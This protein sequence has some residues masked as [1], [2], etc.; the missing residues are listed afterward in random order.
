M[1][2]KDELKKVIDAQNELLR[3]VTQ[4][5][6]KLIRVATTS[7]QRESAKSLRTIKRHISKR[8]KVLNDLTLLL[9]DPKAAS[10]IPVALGNFCSMEKSNVLQDAI[11]DADY[12][13]AVI[14]YQNV[15][16]KVTGALPFAAVV[17]D[18]VGAMQMPVVLTPKS[19]PE[20]KTKAFLPSRGTQPENI[21]PSLFQNINSIT[22]NL[23]VA[24]EAHM[25]L[26]PEL[27]PPRNKKNWTAAQMAQGQCTATIFNICSSMI[28][29]LR[30]S[31]LTTEEIIIDIKKFIKTA[32]LTTNFKNDPDFI[33]ALHNARKDLPPLVEKYPNVS[34]MIPERL[35]LHAILINLQTDN[36]RYLNTHSPVNKKLK[37]RSHFYEADP[38]AKLAH[39]NLRA[40]EL[41]EMLETLHKLPPTNK[42]TENVIAVQTKFKEFI[43]RHQKYEKQDRAM[44]G[45]KDTIGPM[46]SKAKHEFQEKVEDKVADKKTKTRFR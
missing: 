39:A 6:R 28:P 12:K 27:K 18:P 11:S 30:E 2:I 15:L 4:L 7:A 10:G 36:N 44:R 23:N 26:H 24:N 21:A 20:L 32:L 33:T 1:S 14:N 37:R 38:S 31:K 46:L 13:T 16:A 3:T 17:R 29:A 22:N 25:H 41:E 35:S 5:R 34:E 43:E 9:N 42:P 45:E 8:L 19:T 40:L